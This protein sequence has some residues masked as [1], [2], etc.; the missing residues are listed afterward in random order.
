MLIHIFF[1]LTDGFQENLAQNIKG[2]WL[3]LKLVSEGLQSEEQKVRK[4]ALLDRRNHHSSRD[5]PLLHFISG[6]N[7]KSEPG[8]GGSDELHVSV[9]DSGLQPPKS[10]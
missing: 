2:R 4:C 10:E 5:I 3:R 9:Q 6:T 8:E 7:R 1:I